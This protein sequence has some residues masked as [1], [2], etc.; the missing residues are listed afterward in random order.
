MQDFALA[1]PVSVNPAAAGGVTVATNLLVNEFVQPLEEYSVL[2]TLGVRRLTGLQGN[3][4]IPRG[5]ARL[6]S[7]WIQGENQ[8]T[9]QDDLRP[10]DDLS[11]TPKLVGCYTGITLQMMLQS[12]MDMMGLVMQQMRESVSNAIEDAFF[13]GTGTAGQPLGLFSNPNVLT[14]VDVPTGTSMT[15]EHL[16]NLTHEL[17][18]TTRQGKVMMK[19]IVGE[20]LAAYFENTLE[21]PGG[22]TDKRLLTRESYTH[23]EPGTPISTTIVNLLRGYPA[24]Y[25]GY[26]PSRHLLVGDFSQSLLAYWAVPFLYRDTN[27]KTGETNLS[28]FQFVDMNVLRPEL[29]VKILNAGV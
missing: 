7:G 14:S 13:N 18:L 6:V 19:F 24:Y 16:T 17:P 3:Y 15:F 12:S 23:A 2:P 20:E 1:D 8:P 25:S 22:G 26:V 5:N 29:F 28:I 27:I 4:V 10:F 21:T 9:P 11:L